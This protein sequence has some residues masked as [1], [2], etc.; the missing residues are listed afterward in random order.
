MCSLVSSCV[1]YGI[2]LHPFPFVFALCAQRLRTLV[3]TYF[4]LSISTASHKSRL[5]RPSHTSQLDFFFSSSSH[6]RQPLY[7]H[8]SSQ[9]SLT[10]RSERAAHFAQTETQSISQHGKLVFHIDQ[11]IARFFTSLTE[12]SHQHSGRRSANQHFV[13]ILD[14]EY[15]NLAGTAQK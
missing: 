14:A 6:M 12:C 9:Q 11:N 7:I 1:I 5:S 10:K 3:F 8:S 13:T 4:L 2:L 15:S